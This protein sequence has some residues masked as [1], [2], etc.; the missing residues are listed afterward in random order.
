VKEPRKNRVLTGRRF[1]VLV[2]D[3]PWSFADK[4]GRKRG[5]ARQY[6]VLSLDEIKKFPLPSLAKDAFLFLW[7]VS[8]QVE[9]AYE[10]VRYW[11]FVP[12]S[13]IVWVKKT[14]HGNRHMGMGRTVRGEHEVCIVATRGR[15][16]VK[17]R[18]IRSTFDAPVGRHSA[19]PEAFFDLVEALA[20]GPYVELFARRRRRGWTCIG[21]EVDGPADRR[22]AA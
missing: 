9:E 7:R 3:P 6:Q 4:L 16:R 10:V 15:P 19:K 13:E 17:S 1:A 14:K 22:R 11:G 18:G 20:A 2:A 5:A 8:S 21:N 12:K